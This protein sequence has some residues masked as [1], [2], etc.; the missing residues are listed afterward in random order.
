MTK[1]IITS[2]NLD[3]KFRKLEKKLQL[4]AKSRILIFIKNPFSPIL[5]NHLLHGDKK[6]IRSINISG[7]LRLLYK[8]VSTDTIHFI[9]IDTHSN[10]Y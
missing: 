10:L 9:D 8:E 2:K 7:D 5:N 3:K 1:T 4:Q 6:L